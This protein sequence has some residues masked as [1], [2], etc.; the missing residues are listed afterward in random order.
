MRGA[1]PSGC[2]AMRSAFGRSRRLGATPSRSTAGARIGQHEMPAPVHDDAGKRVV[3]AEHPLDPLPDGG[4]VRVVEGP[5][6]ILGSETRGQKQLILL[7]QW[8]VENIGEPEHHRT[9]RGRSTG[10]DEAHVACRHVG[11]DREVELA[12]PAPLSPIAH[13]RAERRYLHVNGGHGPSVAHHR[14]RD[15]Y[16]RGNC[17]PY[18]RGGP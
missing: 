8:Y 6:A 2:R 9:T 18:L 3:C 7:A 16:V 10:L 13:Q 14:G 11:L 4:H 15:H 5:L 17:R 1:R 12:Q